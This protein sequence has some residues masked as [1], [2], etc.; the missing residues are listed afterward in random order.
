MEKRLLPIGTV[1]ILKGGTKKAMI[2][3]YCPVAA[4]MPDK[5][6]DYRGCPYP[7]GII[8][9]EGA[10]LFDHDQIDE[11]VHKG[12]ENDEVIDFIDRLEIILNQEND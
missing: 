1:V 6:F 12:F 7:E 2:T 10:A 5:T 9:S 11:V 4:E 3:G 8:I